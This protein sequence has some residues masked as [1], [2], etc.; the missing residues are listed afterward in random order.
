[1]GRKERSVKQW[2]RPLVFMLF[3]SSGKARDARATAKGETGD[4]DDA[5]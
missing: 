5:R 1:M 2:A 3:P 4:D